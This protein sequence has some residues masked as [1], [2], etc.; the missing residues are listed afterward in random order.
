MTNLQILSHNICYAYLG[1]DQNNA[2]VIQTSTLD[3]GRSLEHFERFLQEFYMR[4]T[5]YNTIAKIPELLTI[6]AAEYQTITSVLRHLAYS[7]QEFSPQLYA[8][9]IY[10]PYNWAGMS[11]HRLV[12]LTH[13]GA[14]DRNN[15]ESAVRAVAAQEAADVHTSIVVAANHTRDLVLVDSAAYHSLAGGEETV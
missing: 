4:R 10:R 2:P 8:E 15:I 5:G 12:A 6:L 13:W 3:I 11:Y 9:E 1:V 14:C 7:N